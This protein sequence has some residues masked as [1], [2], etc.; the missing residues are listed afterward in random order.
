[1]ISPKI[2]PILPKIRD[3]LKNQPVNKA[4]LFGSFS[5][6]EETPESDIDILV[7][8]D[9]S[10]GIV[11]LFKMGAM[12]MDLSD[13]AGHRVDLVDNR[14]LLSFARESVDKDKILIYERST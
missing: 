8:F 9:H 14:G 7:D 12:L 13:I 2:L 3:F 10:N 1:M 5:R 11:S 6:G 4:W